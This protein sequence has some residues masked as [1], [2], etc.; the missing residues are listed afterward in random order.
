M[1]LHTKAATDEVYELFNQSLSDGDEHSDDTGSASSSEEDEDDDGYTTGGES[2]GTGRISGTTSEI[3]EETEREI[4]DDRSEAANTTAVEATEDNTGWSEFTTSKHMPKEDDTADSSVEHTTEEPHDN[5]ELRASAEE[6]VA[7][8][9]VD[10]HSHVEEEVKTPTS[11]GLPLQDSSNRFV[12]V[13]P[14]DYHAP[15]RPYR[16][17]DQ[18]A[19]NRLPFMTP[20]VEKTESSF[21]TLTKTSKDY[22]TSKTPC[23]KASQKTPQIVEDNDEVWSSPFQETDVLKESSRYNI[24]STNSALSPQTKVRPALPP[25]LKTSKSFTKKPVEASKGPIIRDAQCNP[26]ALDVHETILHEMQPSLSSYEGFFDRRDT[27]SGRKPEIHKYCRSVAASKAKHG[28]DKTLSNLSLPPML[29]LD[30]A[31]Q[32]YVIKR[33][34]GAGAFAP[35]YLAEALADDDSQDADEASLGSISVSRPG[36]SRPTLQALKMEDP[37]SAWEFYM[38]QCAHRRLGVSR[39]AQSIIQAYEMH[40]F[41]DEG[42]LLE[43]YRDQG[44]LLDLVNVVAEQNRQAGTTSTGMDECLAMFFTIEILR[45]VEALHTKSII[46]G[47]LKADNVLVRFV[48]PENETD[49]SSHYSRDGSAGWSAKGITLIDFGR[50]VDMRHFMPNVQFIADWPTSETDCAEMRELRPWTYQ[51]DY[52]GIA[53]IAHT[54]LFGKY[55]ETVTE[56]G[57]IGAGAAKTYRLKEGLKRWWQVD[58]WGGFFALML[59]PTRRL[60]RED[61]VRMPVTIGLREVREKMEVWLEGNGEKGVGLRNWIRRLEVVLAA[62]RRP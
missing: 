38:L 29:R 5:S 39:P 24:Q 53:A 15:T 21:G 12:P 45:T 30:G 43:E 28:T 4:E 42:Y 8:I 32:Q 19:A 41:A 10:E 34:L 55:I 2:T 11:P 61:G 51:A 22:F 62:K 59:N 57:G 47:D 56:K 33:E 31:K 23:P 36:R 25:T 13:Q 9:T 54:M 40:L 52:H 49:V 27:G 60:E 26:M 44:T 20:I 16:N 17:P 1:T 50:G 3:G 14:E 46:H 35:V 48:Q 7:S 18:V 37:P 6:R 58:I